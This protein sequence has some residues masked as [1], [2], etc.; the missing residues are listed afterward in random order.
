VQQ[1][2]SEHPMTGDER[3]VSRYT[4]RAEV[5][6]ILGPESQDAFV[7]LGD[8]KATVE[9]LSY[10]LNTYIGDVPGMVRGQAELVLDDGMQRPEV[11]R[12]LDNMDRLTEALVLTLDPETI[13]G[14]WSHAFAEIR[15]ERALLM[16]DIDQQRIA[17]FGDISA[18]RVAVIEALVAEREILSSQLQEV[19]LETV[20]TAERIVEETVS[21][22]KADA[23]DL[24]DHL[25][26]RLAQ[27]MGAVFAVVAV[28]AVIAWG[29]L[30][31][32]V[33][34]RRG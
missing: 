9:E 5:A 32:R 33:P 2:A 11:V 7:V 23:F 13:E 29:F 8:T 21:Q 4:G 15:Q 28:V 12:M 19:R 27:L 25:F 1:V 20:A 22:A 6:G 10:R 3:I 30:R 26:L 14:I 24:I 18:Q 31:S 16:K 17:A 34:F